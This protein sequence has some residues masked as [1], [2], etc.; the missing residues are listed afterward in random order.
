MAFKSPSSHFFVCFGMLCADIFQ[1][2][3]NELSD[4]GRSLPRKDIM[5][6][7]HSSDAK[8][9]IDYVWLIHPSF[10]AWLSFDIEHVPAFN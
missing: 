9:G 4:E 3:T 7:L 5:A 8:A 6:Q 1:L 10:L 2:H